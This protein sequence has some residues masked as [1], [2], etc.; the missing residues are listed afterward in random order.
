MTEFPLTDKDG[1][2]TSSIING[3]L[4]IP[5]IGHDQDTF[6]ILNPSSDIPA[7]ETKFKTFLDTKFG[8]WKGEYLY[9]MGSY[10]E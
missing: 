10:I 5:R 7:L 8:K 6:V 4:S 9:K 2:R 3:Y 1:V